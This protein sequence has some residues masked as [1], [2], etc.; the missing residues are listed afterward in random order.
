MDQ[1]QL[2]TFYDRAPEPI[3]EFIE[4][5]RESYGLPRPGR[6][7]DMG[8]G[9]GRLLEPLAASDWMVTGYEPDPEYAAAARR[10]VAP[11]TGHAFRE[12][13]FL[14]L[15]DRST[16]DLIVAVNDPYLYLREPRSRREALRR[17]CEALRPGGVLFLEQANFPWILKNYREPA[18][19]EFDVDGSPVTRIAAHEIDYHRGAFTHHDVFTWVD[20]SGSEASARKTHRFAMIPFEELKFFLEELGFEA[21]RTFNDFGDRESAEISG[22]RMLVAARRG[23]T[24]S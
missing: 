2:Y 17:C 1:S 4:Y 15:D 13:G 12:A 3:V 10:V 24:T 14:D 18:A 5:L 21:V 19:I 11:M 16:F 7:L 6:V 9:P 23:R 8:C 22:K 20:S